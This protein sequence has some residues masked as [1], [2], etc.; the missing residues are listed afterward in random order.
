LSTHT[1]WYA[2]TPQANLRVDANTFGSSYDT[3]ISAYTGSPGALTQIDCN[4]DAQG[5]QSQVIFDVTAGQTYY[6]MVGAFDSSA[7]GDLTLTLRQAPP[8]PPAPVVRLSI[9]RG[10]SLDRS[11]TATVSGRVT[12]N[13]PLYVSLSGSLTQA[14][15]RHRTAEGH[16]DDG[17]F[18]TPPGV[19]WTMTMAAS[20]NQYSHGPAQADIGASACNSDGCTLDLSSARVT[21]RAGHPK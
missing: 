19:P 3:T 13:Q 18:C 15:G 1:V 4:D 21:L 9:D 12:C 10:A 20:G 8:P 16:G 14:V 7:G 17:V 6:I 11:A 2:Y 5:A